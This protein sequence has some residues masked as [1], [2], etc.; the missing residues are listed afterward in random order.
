MKRFPQ[1][2]WFRDESS[3]TLVLIPSGFRCHVRDCTPTLSLQ[4][5][6]DKGGATQVSS[7]KDWASPPRM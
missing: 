3:T 2:C 7:G 1:G 6:R 4:S 5:G